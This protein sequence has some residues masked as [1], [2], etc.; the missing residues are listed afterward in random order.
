MHDCRQYI[1]CIIQGILCHSSVVFPHVYSVS[2]IT[3][4]VS[5]FSA[6]CSP[7]KLCLVLCITKQEKIRLEQNTVFSVPSLLLLLLCYNTRIKFS[8][9]Y[10]NAG[11]YVLEIKYFGFFEKNSL[12]KEILQPK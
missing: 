11:Q 12:N 1:S 6:S 10:T 2:K 8:I 9:L 5:S 7:G 4:F 3:F